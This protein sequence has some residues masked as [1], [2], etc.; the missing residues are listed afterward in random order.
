MPS[1]GG[2]WLEIRGPCAPSSMQGAR[3]SD[4]ELT[5]YGPP[6]EGQFPS[7]PRC[8]SPRTALKSGECTSAASARTPP[9]PAPPR[10][11]PLTGHWT[12]AP[13]A[14]AAPSPPPPPPPETAAATA[15]ARAQ[16]P[17]AS[18]PA[19]EP[20]LSPPSQ[21]RP[22]LPRPPLPP[23]IDLEFYLA[24]ECLQLFAHFPPARC[25]PRAHIPLRHTF[26]WRVKRARAHTKSLWNRR[27]WRG[28]RGS[29]S[30]LKPQ[31]EWRKDTE[32][33]L[34]GLSGCS[35]QPANSK[36]L[37]LFFFIKHLLDV[38]L[39]SFLCEMCECA[40]VKHSAY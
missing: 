38:T 16:E 20:P 15:S 5:R 28:L 8:R 14:P 35:R 29:G 21:P 32:P 4:P 27:E 13:A 18:P 12:T 31:R 3:S 25:G 7:G 34:R 9:R 30:S 33:R 36:C 39:A 10:F 26:T 23:Q 1:S 22:P 40:I 19:P 6:S 2:A 11:V 24:L 17:A 37:R